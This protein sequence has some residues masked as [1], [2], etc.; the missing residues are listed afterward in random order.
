VT[1]PARPPSVRLVILAGADLLVS[2]QRVKGRRSRPHAAA[3]QAAPDAVA[4]NS[5]IGS[6]DDGPGSAGL[7]AQ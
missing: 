4:A 2:G 6:E 7:P 1:L 3:C 5:T